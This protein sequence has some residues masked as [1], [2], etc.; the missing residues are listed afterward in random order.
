MTE[1]PIL[2][3]VEKLVSVGIDALFNLIAAFDSIEW[4]GVLQ[5]TG[6]Y[7]SQLLLE[8]YANIKG[9]E[10]PVIQTVISYVKG[11]HIHFTRPIVPSSLGVNDEGPDII[12]VKD[13]V[14]SD[15]HS[16]CRIAEII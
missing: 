15:P 3:I 13:S 8:F 1:K 5:L 14:K 12:M 7:Y 2:S 11:H 16:S 6:A 9:K 4:I 10:N